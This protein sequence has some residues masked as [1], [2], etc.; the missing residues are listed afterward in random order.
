M[1]VLI[2]EDELLI[3]MGLAMV[4]EDAGH[5]VMCAADGAEAVELAGKHPARFVA[6]VTDYRMPGELTG[7]DLIKLLR[8]IYPAIP[9]FIATA[10]VD[11]VSQEFREAHGVRVFG[12]PYDPEALVLS[13]DRAISGPGAA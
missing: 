6:V 13:L 4:L 8:P 5:E 12:K 2:V 9:M 3:R 1:C 11:A 10:T 7:T